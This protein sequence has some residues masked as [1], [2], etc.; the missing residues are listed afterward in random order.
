MR[1]GGSRIP[2]DSNKDRDFAIL[3][4]RKAGQVTVVRERAPVMLTR[5]VLENYFGMPLSVAARELVSTA[6]IFKYLRI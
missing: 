2:F 6:L 1:D 5:A 4:R 3:P